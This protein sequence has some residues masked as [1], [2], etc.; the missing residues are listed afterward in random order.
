MLP[1]VNILIS[2]RLAQ[3]LLLLNLFGAHF[4]SSALNCQG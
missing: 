1:Q 3:G 2:G 4:K